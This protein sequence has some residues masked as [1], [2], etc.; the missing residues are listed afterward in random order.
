MRADFEVLGAKL[1]VFCKSG[2]NVSA[3]KKVLSLLALPLALASCSV[4]GVPNGDVTGTI[5]NA[6]TNQGTIRLAVLGVSFGGISNTSVNQIAVTPGSGGVYSIS[7]PQNPS[8]GGYEVI[9]YADTNN[10]GQYESGEPRTQSNGKTLV[11][12][13]S[14]LVGTFTGLSKGWNLVQNGQIVKS[15]TPFNGYDLSF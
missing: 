14:N 4:F 12:T 10:D 9:A 1:N 8:D 13:S 15:G 2:P 5:S 6:P 7:L 11:Y 3:M